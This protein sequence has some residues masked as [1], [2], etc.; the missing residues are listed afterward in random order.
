MA[1]PGSRNP[2]G[3]GIALFGLGGRVNEVA[4][5]A[6]AFVH[7]DALFIFAAETTWA[8]ND[9]PADGAAIFAAGRP[10]RAYQNFPDPDLA[11]WRDA[12]YGGNYRRLVA[13][14]HAYDPTAFFSYLQAVGRCPD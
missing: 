8:D 9:S 2:D 6:T 3:A 12:Y 13:V 4:P 14:K 1:W 7:R 10:N 5:D 11:D